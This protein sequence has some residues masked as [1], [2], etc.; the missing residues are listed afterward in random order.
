MRT[1][2]LPCRE[3]QEGRPA[4]PT[5]VT[6]PGV[7]VVCGSQDRVGYAAPVVQASLLKHAV[8]ADVVGSALDILRD[9]L[10][11]FLLDM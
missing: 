5:T 2:R 7:P 1:A 9:L 6:G 4:R 8:D 10:D 11:I 3:N